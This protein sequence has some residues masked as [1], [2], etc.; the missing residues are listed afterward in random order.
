ML[1]VFAAGLLMGTA[2][3]AATKSAPSATFNR[4]VLPILQQRCQECHRP[5]EV[6]PMSFVTYKETRPWA[7]AIKDSILTKKMPP[8]FADR[9]YGNFRNERTLTDAET[10]TILAWVEN[11]A[12]EGDEEDKPAPVQF[13]EGWSIGKPDMVVEFPRDLQIPAT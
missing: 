9:N 8:W 6:A 10:G 1:R 13:A 12:P 7:K 5:G 4:D 3:I 2:V 11:G